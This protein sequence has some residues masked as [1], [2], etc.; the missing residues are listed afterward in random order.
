MKAQQP[1]PPAHLFDILPN[2]HATLSYLEPSL[3][4][5]TP[6]TT[7]SSATTSFISTQSQSQPI[8]SV[9]DDSKT[10]LDNSTS[11]PKLSADSA[12]RCKDLAVAASLDAKAKIRKIFAELENLDDMHRTVDQQEL[13]I[14]N[15]KRKISEQ[16]EVLKRLGEDAKGL[17]KDIGA[18]H[19]KP[20]DIIHELAGRK[21]EDM[22]P[23]PKTD[24]LIM[25]EG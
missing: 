7:T 9:E 17:Q 11:G 5:Y 23:E 15:L 6:D 21:E 18:D 3:N 16:K 25:G 19:K 20:E 4:V 8:K 12:T 22:G 10:S 13:E 1:L 24:D 2:L 14:S